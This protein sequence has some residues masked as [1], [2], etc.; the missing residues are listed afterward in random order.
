VNVNKR[1]GTPKGQ[2]KINNPDKLETLGSQDTGRRQ[3]KQKHTTMRK[4]AQIK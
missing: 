3:T 2:S 4:Q 1:Q